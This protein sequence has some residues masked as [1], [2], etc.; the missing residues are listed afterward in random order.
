MKNGLIVGNDG[1]KRYY[2]DGQYHR[3]DGPSI[4]SARGSKYY[5]I[6]GKLHR[7][8]GPA[9][10]RWNNTKEWYLNGKEYSEDEFNEIMLK[11]KLKMLGI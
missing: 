4:V 3:E 6:N 7:E 5:H 2:K 1:A 10:D 11:K 9:I 8:D